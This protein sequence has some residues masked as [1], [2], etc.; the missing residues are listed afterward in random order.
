MDSEWLEVAGV[1]SASVGYTGS[2]SPS[3]TYKSVCAGDG[4]TEAVRVEFDPSQLSYEGLIR[5]FVEDPKVPNIYGRQDPQYQVAI[6]A[7]SP[8]QREAAQKVLAE[9]GKSVPILKATPWYDAEANHQD[10]FGP[11]RS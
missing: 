4:H 2:D 6:W 11:S 10:F 1:L 5:R 7:C 9:A 3:P 8:S